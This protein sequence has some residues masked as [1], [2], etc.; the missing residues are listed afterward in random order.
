MKNNGQK[1]V[2]WECQNDVI[3]GQKCLRKNVF[4]E[5]FPNNLYSKVTKFELHGVIGS[6][7]LEF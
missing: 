1:I 7:P 5:M 3:G 4:F 6:G 2:I